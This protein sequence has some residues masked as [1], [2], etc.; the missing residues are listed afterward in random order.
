MRMT[1]RTVLSALALCPSV[2]LLV[3]TQEALPP[4]LE[5]PLV[6]PLE[7]AAGSMDAPAADPLQ[8]VSGRQIWMVNAPEADCRAAESLGLLVTCEPQRPGAAG[9]E[10]VVW[11]PEISQSSAAALVS[12]LGLQGVVVRTWEGQPADKNP[13]ECGHFYEITLRY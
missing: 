5:T 6:P 7:E 4:P 2:L 11:C 1:S 3:A 9:P 12:A 10:I 8:G 13:E